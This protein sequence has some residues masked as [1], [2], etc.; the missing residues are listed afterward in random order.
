MKHVV[1]IGIVVTV[2]ALSIGFALVQAQDTTVQGDIT[3][4]SDL[5]LSLYV[6]ERYLGYNDFRNQLGASGMDTST[7]SDTARF[8][9]GQYG[10]LFN[11]YRNMNMEMD[12]S[13]EATAA[14]DAASAEATETV[15]EGP[16]EVAGLPQYNQAGG[17]FDPAFTAGA[18]S[19]YAF[20]DAT[21]DQSF[22]SLFPA[23]TDTS[24]ISPLAPSTIAGE[25]AECTQL[26]TELNRFYRSL[27]F[28]DFSGMSGMMGGAQG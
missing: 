21:F 17:L 24:T 7:M 3:C 5:I 13:A 12:M 11:N 14:V 16:E 10:P 22:Q 26:R 27:A 23:G 1:R 4:D 6:A 2:F 19:A 20:D 28:S 9:Y 18:A 25:A 15:G 8:N